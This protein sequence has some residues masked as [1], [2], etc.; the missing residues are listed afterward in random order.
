MYSGVV[1][2]RTPIPISRN[3]KFCPDKTYYRYNV[4]FSYPLAV[5]YNATRLYHDQIAMYKIYRGPVLYDNV[6][7]VT[8]AMARRGQDLVLWR[9]LGGRTQHFT[10]Y[11][12]RNYT[13]I[14]IYCTNTHV[15]FDGY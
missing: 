4:L 8:E 9:G 3:G 1:L 11:I 12:Q 5:R 15:V 7:Y 14:I 10:F 2:S 13:N 6:L